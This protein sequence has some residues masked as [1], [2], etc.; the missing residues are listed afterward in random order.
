[1]FALLSKLISTS[2][3]FLFP[4]YSSYKAI[5]ANEQDAIESWLMY[6]VVMAGLHVVEVTVEWT[7]SWIPFYYEAKCIVILWLTL[8]QIQG[9]TY[10]YVTYINP[11]LL[12]HESDIDKT[13][14]HTKQQAKAAGLDYMR[15]A[16]VYARE[17]IM[18]AIMSSESQAQAMDADA[19]SHNEQPKDRPQTTATPASTKQAWTFANNMLR[20]YGPA[21]VAA[22]SSLF[23]PLRN[24]DTNSLHA[25][26]PLDDVS[27][28]K[29]YDDLGIAGPAEAALP[30]R[31]RLYS[32]EMSGNARQD[33]RIPSASAAIS[34]ATGATA[35]GSAYSSYT[36]AQLRQRRLELERELAILENSSVAGSEGSDA[37][38]A[39]GLT[40]A[41]GTIS[42][43]STVRGRHISAPSLPL[44]GERISP[45]LITRELE[46]STTF[47][48]IGQE[49]VVD[50]GTLPSD[51]G[52]NAE[53]HGWKG[54]PDPTQ[55]SYGS[56][57]STRSA[58]R[59][60]QSK[61]SS[62]SFWGGSPSQSSG[63]QPVAGS[64]S[65]KKDA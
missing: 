59:P 25:D 23:R 15:R 29:K 61:R 48:R 2:V 33:R 32:Q 11:F 44:P 12:Q 7:V 31:E 39:G 14:E 16:Y 6:W 30:Q 46:A 27:R 5:R 40:P 19:Q 21:A 4:V 22:G 18:R 36:R 9:S 26:A 20:S 62:W 42:T 3:G 43:P 49:D 47:E 17:A 52:R 55:M 34:G 13:V 38:S 51:W 58:E 54:A 53:K 24:V 10:I 1:M 45:A 65:S 41:R 56:P 64:E 57:L 50:Q 8:P 37:A 35:S 28:R 63:G 60:A